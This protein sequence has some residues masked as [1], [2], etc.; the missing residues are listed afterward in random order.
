MNVTN[1]ARVNQKLAFARV[2]LQALQIDS[3]DKPLLQQAMLEA[4]CFHLYAAY[5]AYLKEIGD[6]YK[7]ADPESIGS[8]DEL[9]ARLAAVGKT[10]TES[11]ELVLLSREPGNWL[12]H[13]IACYQN[14]LAARTGQQGGDKVGGEGVIPVV[15]VAEN[16]DSR[17]TMANL[18][19]W[20]Q[21]LGTLIDRQRDSMTEY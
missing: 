1:L 10:P 6:S 16:G 7:V 2:S 13:L 20:Q 18:K 14:C 11:R 12:Y 8:I 15:P 5:L 3:G 21:E 9:V 4:C 17:C 19:A